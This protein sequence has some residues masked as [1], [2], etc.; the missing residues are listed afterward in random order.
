MSGA[1]YGVHPEFTPWSRFQ[2]QA[3]EPSCL[4]LHWSNAPPSPLVARSA[5]LCRNPDRVPGLS[6]KETRQLKNAAP[7]HIARPILTDRLSDV[8]R[9]GPAECRLRKNPE[10]KVKLVNRLD[11]VLTLPRLTTESWRSEM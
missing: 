8:A 1:L 6:S 2:S 4:I 7:V 10:G 3:V 9:V 5:H 11:A